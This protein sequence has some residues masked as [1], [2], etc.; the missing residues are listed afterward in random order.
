MWSEAYNRKQENEKKHKQIIKP[1]NTM[2]DKISFELLDEYGFSR[3]NSHFTYRCFPAPLYGNFRID[4]NE[5]GEWIICAWEFYLRQVET[6][7][8]VANFYKGIC[9]LEL[10]KTKQ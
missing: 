3:F 9:D 10:E 4:L 7:E 8:Q 6:M 2:N 5:R 1:I